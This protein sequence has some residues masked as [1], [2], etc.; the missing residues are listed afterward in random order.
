MATRLPRPY[1]RS[2]TERRIDLSDPGF[3]PTD[4]EL[5]GLAHRAFAGVKERHE[6][7]LARIRAEIA[8]VTQ[9]S[10]LAIDA[11]GAAR[12]SK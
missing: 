11:R 9:R 2:V 1:T 5:V 10:L 4:E 6:A 12:A 3:E 8:T 7:A